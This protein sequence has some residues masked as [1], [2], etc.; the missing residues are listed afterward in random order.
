MDVIIE[1]MALSQTRGGVT[2]YVRELVSHL[3]SLYPND[4]I[5]ILYG[6]TGGTGQ[7]HPQTTETVIPLRSEVLLPYWLSYPV[8]RHIRSRKIAVSHFTK[9]ALPRTA[10][11]PTVVTIYDIIPLLL[12]ESQSPLRR[13]Y[14]PAVL[15]HAAKH[16]S[17]IMTISEQ[18]KKD[19][20]E[21]YGV[22]DANI[23]VTPLAVDLEHFKP[24]RSSSTLGVS[25]L[26]PR[27]FLSR[28]PYILFVGTKDRRKNISSLIRAFAAI[29]DKV[30][31]RLLIAGKQAHKK[32]T[33]ELTVDSCKLQDRV[34]FLENVSY[35]ELPALYSNADIFVWP[36]VYEGW[37]FPPQEAMACGT[38]V[39][40]SNGGPLPE[41]VGDAGII[42]PFQSPRLADRMND[43]E[44]IE[45]LAHEMLA[46]ISDEKK[47]SE[48]I[49]RGLDRVR[50]FSWE[51]VARK[52]HEAY[53]KVSL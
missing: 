30:P 11:G 44:F 33:S 8:A 37:G 45:N 34:E 5:E 21:R 4:K 40:V 41:V 2:T 16:A 9:A 25:P 17:H 38:P 6:N 51:D 22:T 20:M 28:K 1:A 7:F 15:E 31:H 52:T 53:V 36:S 12:P 46:L 14:W 10:V 18:S 42:V 49:R 47:K 3:T 19:I 35:S 39:I 48:L 26:T 43:E 24:E 50:Q 23:T 32:D 29:A 13:L 27:V